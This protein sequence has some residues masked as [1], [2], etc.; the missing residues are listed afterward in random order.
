M[1][2]GPSTSVGGPSTS[3]GVPA[4]VWGQISALPSTATGVYESHFGPQMSLPRCCSEGPTTVVGWLLV[5]PGRRKRERERETP[6][7]YHV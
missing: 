5:D 3:V 1:L 2:G 6:P 7:R 4:R